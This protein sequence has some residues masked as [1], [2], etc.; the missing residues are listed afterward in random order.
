MSEW[1]AD[2][3]AAMTL[4][5]K[6]SL[7]GGSNRFF[8]RALPEHGVPRVF[9][10]DSTMGVRLASDIEDEALR[11]TL[12]RTTAFP[13]A[14]LL[15]ATWNPDLAERYARAVG[16]ECRAAGVP[17]ALVTMSWRRLADQIHCDAAVDRLRDPARGI[18]DIAHELGYSDSANFTRAFRRWT[19][20]SPQTYRRQQS[21]NRP[22]SMM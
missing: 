14:I 13:S 9:L 3:L 5:E 16:E 1:V 7:L 2:T 19:G 20:V 12:E 17:C 15:A 8:I 6:I 21:T 18:T 4:D 22:E 10:A 11:P